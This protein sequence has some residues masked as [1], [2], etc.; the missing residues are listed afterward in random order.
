ML[1]INFRESGQVTDGERT[2][3]N[4]IL[5]YDGEYKLILI[6]IPLAIVSIQYKERPTSLSYKARYTS[7]VTKHLPVLNGRS[8]P[9]F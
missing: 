1:Y 6:R 5:R 3:D 9:K 8:C 4:I 2:G 7:S